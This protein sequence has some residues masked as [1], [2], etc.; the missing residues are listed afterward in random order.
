MND[1][2]WKTPLQI[3]LILAAAAMII[4]GILNGSIRDVWGKAV[5]LCMECVG[6]G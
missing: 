2:R 5:K 1:T 4:A 3:I 6:I